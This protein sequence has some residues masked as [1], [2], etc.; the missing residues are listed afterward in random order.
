MYLPL[1]NVR[2]DDRV[3]VENTPVRSV[4][5]EGKL[6][7]RKGFCDK[8]IPDM[9]LASWGDDTLL[10]TSCQLV[11]WSDL[12]TL[13]ELFAGKFAGGRIDSVF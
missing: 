9:M 3:V 12:L 13:V 6:L 7:S 1:C 2:V 5:E 11:S 8:Y 4:G 10:V